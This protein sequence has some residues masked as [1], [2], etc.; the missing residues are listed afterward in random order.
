VKVSD[1]DLKIAVTA[2]EEELKPLVHHPSSQVISRILSNQ[3]L[4]EDLA[5]VIANRKNILP[6]IIELLYHNRKWK[7]CYRIVHALCKNPRTPQKISLSL[8]KSLRI[9]DI[10]D[11]TR[12]KQVPITLRAKAEAYISEKMLSIPLGIKIAI[13]RRA[14]GNVLT[15]LIEDGMKQVVD[16]C[17]QSPYITEADICKIIHMEKIAVHVIRQIAEHPKWRLRY[18]VQWSLIRNNKAPLAHVVNYLEKIK[19]PDLRELYHDPEVPTSTKPFI[20][21]ELLDRGELQP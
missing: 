13:A 1:E 16:V 6:E 17:L 12:N 7:E 9:I 3:N 2:T 15:R 21:R 5:L 10:A 20:Y 4:T 8:L 19:T 14:S 18:D 11:L